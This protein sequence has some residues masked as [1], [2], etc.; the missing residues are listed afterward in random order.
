LSAKI[1]ALT[2]ESWINDLSSFAKLCSY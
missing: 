1:E 2:C